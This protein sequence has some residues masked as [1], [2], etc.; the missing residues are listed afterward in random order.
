MKAIIIL[1]LI[2]AG[3]SFLLAAAALGFLAYCESKISPK[4]KKLIRYRFDRY[5]GTPYEIIIR[6]DEVQ[7]Q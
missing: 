7:N 3:L 4:P 2:W 1:V 5:D 6:T